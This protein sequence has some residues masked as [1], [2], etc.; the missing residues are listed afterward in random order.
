[1]RPILTHR[2]SLCGQGR[3]RRP[4]EAEEIGGDEGEFEAAPTGA[5]VD[6]RVREG[7]RVDG[8]ENVAGGGVR[9]VRQGPGRFS[10][11]GHPCSRTVLALYGL[12]TTDYGL[13]A[14]DYRL[15]TLVAYRRARTLAVMIAPK[16]A[17]LMAGPWPKRRA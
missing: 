1:M 4:R 12:P 3:D 17:A 10:H 8:G 6:R 16:E 5:D 2:R 9:A 15:P 7:A 13:R 11:P 14:T